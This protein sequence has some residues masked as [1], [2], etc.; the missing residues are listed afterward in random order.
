MHQCVCDDLPLVW[1]VP[2]GLC[3]GGYN[4]LVRPARGGT[5]R[6]PGRRYPGAG[7]TSGRP[8]QISHKIFH[9]FGL[10]GTLYLTVYDCL[11]TDQGVFYSKPLN[12]LSCFFTTAITL[13]RIGSHECLNN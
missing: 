10:K 13:E 11:K 2:T 4:T 6:C 9:H 1:V 5:P 7:H 12:L 3:S 8:A